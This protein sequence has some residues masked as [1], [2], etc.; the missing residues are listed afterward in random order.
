MHMKAVGGFGNVSEAMS[1]STF[2]FLMLDSR[3]IASTALSVY[4]SWHRHFFTDHAA[5]TSARPSVS[6]G[7]H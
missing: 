1:Q 3:F 4:G 7:T 6:E 2:G 5:M